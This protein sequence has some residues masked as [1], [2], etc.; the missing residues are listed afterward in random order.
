MSEP[1]ADVSGTV[2]YSMDK[3]LIDRIPWALWGCVAGLVIV[4]HTSSR[5]GAGAAVAFVYLALL[6]L[7][8]AGWALT[9]LVARSGISFLVEFPTYLLIA[10]VVAFVIAGVSGSVGATRAYGQLW[11]SNLVDPPTNVLG[12][13]LIYLGIGWIA[14]ALVRHVY[15][16]RPIVMLSPAG[17]AFH[18]SWLRDLLIPWQEVHGVGPLD[19]SDTGLAGATNP[20]LIAVVVPQDFYERHIAPKRSFF[21][22]PGTE[23]MFRSKGQMMQMVLSSSEVAVAP[24]DYRGPIEARWKAFRDRPRPAPE[25]AHQSGSPPGPSVVYGRWTFD[26]TWRQAIPFLAPLVAMAAVGL[27]ASGIARG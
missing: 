1:A 5:G 6:G 27:H 3:W 18:R 21:E 24:K 20:N 12:W 13:M 22:P 4:V 9:T 19:I 14:F 7:A 25:T 16:A 10:F 26:G 15:P 2:A 17:V 11:W 23:F 8:F